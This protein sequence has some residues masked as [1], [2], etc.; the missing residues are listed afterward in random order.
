MKS[1]NEIAD[2]ILGFLEDDWK[3]SKDFVIEEIFKA[4]QE[5]HK[6][7]IDEACERISVLSD[8][9]A[10]KGEGDVCTNLRRE[11]IGIRALI[12]EGDQPKEGE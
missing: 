4:Q 6:E 2:G 5:A 12:T 3:D 7:A 1:A 11:I 8:W 10:S 9:Y